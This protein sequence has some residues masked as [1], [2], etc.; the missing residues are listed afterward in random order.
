MLRANSLALVDMVSSSIQAVFFMLAQ[1]T[2]LVHLELAM[3]RLLVFW[4]S[5]I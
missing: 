2:Q 3:A 4:T 1:C 5:P